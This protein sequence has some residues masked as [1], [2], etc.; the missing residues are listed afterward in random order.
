M[1]GHGPDDAAAVQPPTRRKRMSLM[2]LKTLIATDAYVVDVNAVAAAMLR[3]SH[4]VL[5][6]DEADLA[7]VLEEHE[8]GLALGDATDPRDAG[9][10][11]A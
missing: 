4:L 3:R 11:G 10:R 1:G 8:P 5:E 6:P 2:E 7:A 9:Q